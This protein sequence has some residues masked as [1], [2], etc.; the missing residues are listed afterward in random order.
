[1]KKFFTLGLCLGIL[2]IGTLHAQNAF[3]DPTPG[4]ASEFG[5]AIATSGNTVFIGAPGKDTVYVF[6]GDTKAVLSVLT[7]PYSESGLRL[8]SAI[9]VSGNRAVVGAPRADFGVLDAGAAFLYDASTGAFIDTLFS[10]NRGENDQFGTSVAI[11]GDVLVVGAPNE[12]IGPAAD[13]G[14]IYL[15]Q[16]RTGQFIRRIP[17]PNPNVTAFF[18][19]S[20]AGTAGSKLY[21]GSY[22]HGSVRADAGA[23]FVYDPTNG[24]LLDSLL[25]SDY[26][27]QGDTAI[28]FGYSLALAGSNLVV[29]TPFT[30]EVFLL[31]GN[32]NLLQRYVNP[33]GDI[34]NDFGFAVAASGDQILAASPGNLTNADGVAFLFDTGST[35]P[36]RTLDNP[37]DNPA[38]DFARAVAFLGNDLL[39]GAPFANANTGVVYLVTGQSPPQFNRALPNRT[40]TEGEVLTLI[41]SASDP[42]GDSISFSG[43]NLP[44]FAQ[45]S[46]SVLQLAPQIG[47]AG[48]YP[49]IGVIATDD[50][51]P[52]LSDTAAFTLTVNAISSPHVPVLNEILF[53]PNYEDLAT[54]RIELKNTSDDTVSLDNMVLMIAHNTLV[55]AWY[56]SSI[57]RILPDSLLVVHWLKNGVDDAG[58]VFTGLPF[59]TS[60]SDDVTDDFT[61]NNSG[62]A[63][64]MVLGGR[65]N[66]RP[67][68]LALVKLPAGV[69]PITG[70][71]NNPADFAP[72]MVD[73]ARFGAE[74]TAID[75]AADIAG[76]WNSGDFLA[77]PAEGHSYELK[78]D[79]SDSVQT[80]PDDYELQPN[81]SIGF[82][83]R[84][85]PPEAGHLL[86]SEICVRPRLG[87]FI[88]IFN[89][90]T[91]PISLGNYYLTD[92]VSLR[93]EVYT[94]LVKGK[95]SLNVDPG[96]FFV[97]FPDLAVIEPDSYQTIAF[98]ANS[99]ISHYNENPTYTIRGSTP[100]VANMDTVKIGAGAPRFDD[101][102]EVLILLRWGGESDLVED[103]DYVVWGDF[104]ST[105]LLSSKQPQVQLAE[106]G[107][108]PDAV[109]AAGPLN[110][111]VNKTGLGI[112]GIDNGAGKSY[113]DNETPD[114][115]QTPVGAQTHGFYK[116]WQRRATPRE[117]G[118][119]AAGGNGIAGHDE[120]SEDLA[121]AFTA[122]APSPGEPNPGLDL[123]FEFAFVF[124]T[125][126]GG[127]GDG[128]LHRGEKAHLRLRLHNL[129]EFGTGNLISILRFD[130]PT[131]VVG[132]DSIAFFSNIEP[133]ASGLSL[134]S[135][136]IV[137]RDVPL[138]LLAP[139]TLLVINKYGDSTA[140]S[141]KIPMENFFKQNVHQISDGPQ[142]TAVYGA[143]LTS[144][145]VQTAT[146]AVAAGSDTT[147]Q[148]F[149]RLRNTSNETSSTLRARLKLPGIGMTTFEN[150][151][152]NHI[153]PLAVGGP[154][155]S[156][157]LQIRP[158]ANML[159]GA[160]QGQMVSG[161]LEFTSRELC[162][163]ENCLTQNISAPVAM[164]VPRTAVTVEYFHSRVLVPGMTVRLVEANPAPGM[165]PLTFSCVTDTFGRA[166]FP[167]GSF[168][169]TKPYRIVVDPI[170]NSDDDFPNEAVGISDDDLALCDN[171]FNFVSVFPAADKN[172]IAF[173]GDI[174]TVPN[175]SD[176]TPADV[177]RIQNFLAFSAGEDIPIPGNLVAQWHLIYPADVT[178]PA[179]FTGNKFFTIRAYRR[180]DV[181][182]NWEYKIP[183]QHFEKY[184]I[185]GTAGQL[186]AVSCGTDSRRGE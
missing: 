179:N 124:D 68:A 184:T 32:G 71:P 92:N 81:P 166:E 149:I 45:L 77:L 119:R 178:L 185:G 96:D 10:S 122:A 181:N 115:L 100:D 19:F 152:S 123:E 30:E 64:E 117:F 162:H 132:P 114:S 116:S 75:A 97:R 25:G 145:E 9:A 40:M 135:Y 39:V 131:V 95:D 18:G 37:T 34:G 153:P 7:N 73:F 29:G 86:I 140:I 28:G 22:S 176:F 102:N 165:D 44:S 80:E 111:S 36:A 24:N 104:A 78:D 118:E 88:E 139:F 12:N 61:G 84:P 98:D 93:D 82:H 11:A 51:V 46:D 79:P 55:T 6:D 175:S 49:N 141:P 126:A 63:E 21:A 85:A 2:L 160:L 70:L 99:F 164:T 133:D 105:P 27:A 83:K 171:F 48:V 134:D 186:T 142:G 182:A 173:L 183:D 58:N 5:A 170:N 90:T 148:A 66:D 57:T 65:F 41:A 174:S 147:L 159:L 143:L 127:N 56:F 146:F 33:P 69:P 59:G 52:S 23:V 62:I 38:D 158:G 101:P 107:D 128:I 151:N 157:A 106:A 113:Y 26:D 138:P 74:Q 15:F 94:R 112:D 3:V 150:L 168:D 108:S 136:D 180:G 17:H 42:E 172:R 167:A 177:E 89:P 76:L 121:R 130:T 110:E 14:A 31:N 4:T 120:T 16:A 43:L 156:F 60:G 35:A 47:D 91:S 67:F 8:G 54:E 154:Y 163:T 13:A 129:D 109:I 125:L 144:I 137:A 161:C 20:L 50:G 1:M 53:N 72:F 155:V 169:A 87:E 103:V